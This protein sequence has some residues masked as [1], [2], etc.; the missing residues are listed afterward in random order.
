MRG[1]KRGGVA[2]AC[3]QMDPAYVTITDEASTGAAVITVD[4]NGDNAIS[5]VMAAN[6]LITKV[7]M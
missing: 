2:V 7:Q 5:V 6:N 3:L 1:L 4:G